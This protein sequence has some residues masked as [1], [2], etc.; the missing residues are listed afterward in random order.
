[1]ELAFGVEV[2]SNRDAIAHCTRKFELKVWVVWVEDGKSSVVTI[3]WLFCLVNV[4]V[5]TI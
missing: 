3:H 2:R 5:I 4:L 1:M